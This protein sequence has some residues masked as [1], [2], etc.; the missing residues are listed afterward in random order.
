[1]RTFIDF[2]IAR[3]RDLDLDYPMGVTPELDAV[4]A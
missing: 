1:M 2:M 3:I 4:A